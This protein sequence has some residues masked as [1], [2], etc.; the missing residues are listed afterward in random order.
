MYEKGTGTGRRSREV[1]WKME[2]NGESEVQG[3]MGRKG[4]RR[5]ERLV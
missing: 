2:I 5:R 1:S 4:S 3:G